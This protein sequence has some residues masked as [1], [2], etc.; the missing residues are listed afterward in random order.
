MNTDKIT[1]AKYAIGSYL[2]QIDAMIKAKNHIMDAIS[3]FNAVARP[4]ASE[5]DVAAFNNRHKLQSSVDEL[6]IQI[7]VANV[8]IINL[9]R[10]IDEEVNA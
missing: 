9:K 7:R 5:A 6:E 10:V 1:K 2:A 3:H 8:R 4:N